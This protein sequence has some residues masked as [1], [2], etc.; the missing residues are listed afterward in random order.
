MTVERPPDEVYGFWRDLAGLPRV[1]PHLERVD[2]LD[3]RRSHWVAS[4][5]GRR[6]VEWDAEIVDEQPGRRLA[7]RSVGRTPVPNAGEVTV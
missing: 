2:V 1:L 5:V 7:W 6:R 4:A 3:A